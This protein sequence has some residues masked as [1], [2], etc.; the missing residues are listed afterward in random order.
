MEGRQQEHDAQRRDSDALKDTQG[1]RLEAEPV[2]AIEG[3]GE[4]RDARA[5]ASEID[6]P[7]V[8]Q[9]ATIV[10]ERR[11]VGINSLRL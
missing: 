2:L 4:K 6:Q 7:G 11:D 1:T 9:H 10:L 8:L 3:V 5:K